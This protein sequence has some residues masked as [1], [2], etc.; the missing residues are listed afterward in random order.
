MSD[1]GAFTVDAAYFD[2]SNDDFMADGTAA[3]SATRADGDGF[4]VT[5]GW[6]LPGEYGFGSMKG[7]VQPHVRYQAFNND[8][9]SVSGTNVPSGYQDRWDIG[10]NWY[11][12]GYD[13]KVVLYYFHQDDNADL[14]PTVAGRQSE[15]GRN[16][17]NLGVQLQF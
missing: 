14:N 17:V 11:L 4:Y 15:S 2:Y 8:Q 9:T 12:R 10:I 5:A 13:A 3:G 1:I 16:G 6:Y 7:L